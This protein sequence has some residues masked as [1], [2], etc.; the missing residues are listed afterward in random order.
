[1]WTPALGRDKSVKSMKSKSFVT[2]FC[3]LIISS[4]LFGV[5]IADINLSHYKMPQSITDK[6]LGKCKIDELGLYNDDVCSIYMTEVDFYILGWS[7]D[8]KLSYIEEQT[9][10]SHHGCDLYFHIMDVVTDESVVLMEFKNYTKNYL[11]IKDFIKK[12]SSVFDAFLEEYKIDLS[13][14]QY[15]ELPIKFRNEEISI[16]IDITGYDKET[17][18]DLEII[19]DFN[20]EAVKG[21]KTKVISYEKNRIC[22]KV[23]PVGY[24]KSPYENRAAVIVIYS[25]YVFEDSEMFTLIYGCSLD[26]G[27]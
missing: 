16:K 7:K 23:I 4:N 6:F 25:I 18:V 19:K 13:P 12:N 20:V 15:E 14:P 10:E 3:F 11:N 2:F 26:Y 8:G 17:F 24:V 27:F 9:L 21:D 22:N 5:S 1:M